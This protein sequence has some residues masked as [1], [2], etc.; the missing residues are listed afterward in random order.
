M[1]KAESSFY[2]ALRLARQAQNLTQ[3]ALAA[4]VGCKQSAI[5]MLE[6][7]KPD[8]VN[9]ETLEKIATRLHVDLPPVFSKESTP[10]SI[11]ARQDTAQVRT[12]C[13]DA[14]CLSNIPFALGERV[15]FFPRKRF[16]NEG[17]R[18]PWCGELVESR[19]PECGAPVREG[20]CCT[21]CGASYVTDTVSPEDPQ[22]WALEQR[23]V[24]AEIRTLHGAI[25]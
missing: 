4:E 15:L 25:S 5:S 18:C 19:C 24:Q 11:P 14:Q 6:K 20:A 2:T 3:G 23:K 1:E 17:T 21:A 22:L 8:A 16:L 13:P 9:R 7:G 12:F 10:I